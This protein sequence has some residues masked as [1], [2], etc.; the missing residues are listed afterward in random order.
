[1]NDGEVLLVYTAGHI[2]CATGMHFVLPKK[3]K[4]SLKG[5]GF[6]E[7]DCCPLLRGRYM[8]KLSL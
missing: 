3:G 8:Y 7:E 4:Y 1:M 5:A 2:T 6:Q